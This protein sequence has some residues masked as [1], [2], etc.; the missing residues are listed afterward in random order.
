MSRAYQA[1]HHQDPEDEL[2][3]WDQRVAKFRVLARG[4]SCTAPAP[5][6]GY[7]QLAAPVSHGDLDETSYSSSYKLL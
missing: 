7:F 6:E 3:F 4:R 2:V 1:L 5:Y